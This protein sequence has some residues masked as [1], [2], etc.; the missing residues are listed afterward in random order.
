MKHWV[1]YNCDPDKV[2]SFRRALVYDIA[3]MKTKDEYLLELTR[4]LP[5]NLGKWIRYRLIK[6]LAYSV[7]NNVVIWSGSRFRFIYN[8]SFGNN[9]AISYDCIFQA[10]SGIEVGDNTLIGPGV[11]IWT[12][13][14]IF[15]DIKQTINMQG[16]EGKPVIIGKDCWIGSNCFIKPGTTLP[17]G[18]VLFPD[19]VVNRM[20]IPEYSVLSGNPGKVI[21][22]R[23]RIGITTGWGAIL[24]KT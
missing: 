14:H 19:T 8:I 18:C 11:K 24:R 9:V 16:Y 10:A 6:K 1:K 7:G 22:S 2:Y 23:D 15:K 12:M 20:N 13:N 3:R 17:N 4:N 5:G 21:G